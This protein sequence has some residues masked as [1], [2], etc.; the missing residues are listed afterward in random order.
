MSTHHIIVETI[1]SEDNKE[2][3]KNNIDC[4]SG[5]VND[6]FHTSYYKTTTKKSLHIHLTNLTTWLYQLRSLVVKHQNN[7]WIQNTVELCLCNWFGLYLED[8]WALILTS[9]YKEIG[10]HYLLLVY[11]FQKIN[12]SCFNK[13]SLSMF[14]ISLS[15]S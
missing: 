13:V 7:R 1:Y 4:S 11:L 6:L 9:T 5:F 10:L 15:L 3:L 2:T 8:K 14:A 12:V